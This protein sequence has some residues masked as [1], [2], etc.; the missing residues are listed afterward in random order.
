MQGEFFS[1]SFFSSFWYSIIALSKCSHEIRD[2]FTGAY[3]SEYLR[4]KEEGRWDIRSAAMRA[5]RA[6]AITIQRFG[7]Q[8]GIPWADKIDD[9]EAP[10]KAV[11]SAL[12]P[13][14]NTTIVTDDDSH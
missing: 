7:A 12:S 2:T 4:Q 10:F 11:S 13:P 14:T 6:A 5:N 1:F 8:N 3:A 9:F